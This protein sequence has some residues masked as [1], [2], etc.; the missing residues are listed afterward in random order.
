VQVTLLLADAAQEANGK[1]FIL[2]GGWSL[3]GPDVPPM[4]V[5]V[6][7]E[8]PW[9]EANRRHS[10]ELVLVDAD[11][12]AAVLQG[13]EGREELRVGGDFEV[14][15]PPGIPPGSDIDMP[16]AVNIGPLPLRPGQRYAWQLWINGETHEDWC[17][18][19]TVRAR[20]SSP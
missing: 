18:R 1:L 14:G 19:F 13:A 16:L 10:W 2:G 11:G 8:V 6:K 17:R 20:P 12:Q 15:R 4:A 9:N 7:I 3:T 5:A